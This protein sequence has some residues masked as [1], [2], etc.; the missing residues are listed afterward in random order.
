MADRVDLADQ[1]E[2]RVGQLQLRP[3]AVLVGGERGVEFAAGV[4]GGIGRLEAFDLGQ[5]EQP[6]A[7]VQVV[8]RYDP[9]GRVLRLGRSLFRSSSRK[10]EAG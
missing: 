6:P 5:V 3:L 7:I 4:D 2:R 8:E 10:F 9:Q 1:A